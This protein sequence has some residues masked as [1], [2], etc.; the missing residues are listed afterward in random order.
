MIKK[1]TVLVLLSGGI[2][3]GAHVHN[4][5]GAEK[6]TTIDTAHKLTPSKKIIQTMS[7]HHGS[8]PYRHYHKHSGPII[9]RSLLDIKFSG[10]VKTENLI[11][12][13]QVIGVRQ[14]HLSLF[15]AP[16]VRDVNDC[17]INSHAQFHILA[18]Q[19]RLRT[20]IT[21]PEVWRAKPSSKV[22]VDFFGPFVLNNVIDAQVGFQSSINSVLLRHAYIKLDWERWAILLGQ[23]WHPLV[24]PEAASHDSVT[25]MAAPF[26]PIGRHPQLRFTI[27][28]S[29]RAEIILAAMSQ[30]DFRSN[31]PFGF[32]S[33][34]QRTAIL[35]N[36]HA[37][38]RIF[39]KDHVFGLALDYKRLVP[40]LV[41]TGSLGAFK[42]KEAVNSVSAMGYIKLDFPRV[43][44]GNKLTYASNLTDQVMLG[45]YAVT[46]RD[47]KT[48]KEKYTPIRSVAFL[49]D[50]YLKGA[51]IEPGIIIGALKNIGA[52]EKLFDLSTVNENITG[53][54]RFIIYGNGSNI[55][56]PKLPNPDIVPG[57]KANPPQRLNTI[58]YMITISPRIKWYYKSF[59]VGL[60][61]EY[62]RAAYGNLTNKGKV[63]CAQ[64]V[65]N[66]RVTFAM[67][68]YF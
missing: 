20:D 27:Y 19:T 14:D 37:Q 39:W 67:Y 40:R 3:Y 28:P 62:L 54:N 48:G 13:R 41:T 8:L 60:E 4:D 50:F 26:E 7:G 29:S 2:L 38:S 31:G 63:E 45:G 15:P 36:L 16:P 11:D 44:W 58:D 61:A 43:S 30:V 32:A 59:A 51:Y 53:N 17:D 1:Y 68:Y 18:I 21:G 24:P 6:N 64:P 9:D 22:E 49:S 25:F 65:D 46:K 10:Y 52:R 33:K 57:I 34:Y 5:M 23:Y 56:D 35:P 12:T 66:I 47:A 42:T 55:F